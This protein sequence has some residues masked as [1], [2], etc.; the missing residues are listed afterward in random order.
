MITSTEWARVEREIVT[1]WS[2]GNT[3]D[4]LKVIEDVLTRGS[5]EFRG[6]ALM[7]RGSIQEDEANWSSAEADFIQA[8]GLLSPGSYARYTAEL[9]A[10]HAC[11]RTGETDEASRWYREALLTCMQPVE[12]FSGAVAAKGLLEVTSLLPAADL[13]LV[14]AVIEKS[15]RVLSLPNEPDTQDLAGAI[16]TL[17]QRASNANG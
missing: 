16:E 1:A 7:Y 13:D 15:W 3:A 9:S 8:V 11:K 6:R 2:A 4:A 14:L 12:P 10:A 5:D 17:I